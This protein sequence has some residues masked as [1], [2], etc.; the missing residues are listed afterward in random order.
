MLRQARRMTML[1][2]VGSSRGGDTQKRIQMMTMMIRFHFLR[3]ET[4]KI[5]QEHLFEICNIIN[6]NII[7]IIAIA[8][9]REDTRVDGLS[10]YAAHHPQ[11]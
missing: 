3:T 11:L 8:G 2:V 6:F 1:N 9:H 4:P 7:I 5:N 10:S